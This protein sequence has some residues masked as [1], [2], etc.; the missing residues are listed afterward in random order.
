MT[1]GASSEKEDEVHELATDCADEEGKGVA[2]CKCSAA[3]KLESDCT[4]GTHGISAMDDA[5][6]V[7][8]S[9][10]VS[11]ASICLESMSESVDL[12]TSGKEAFP[13]A[14]FSDLFLLM[15]VNKDKKSW[16]KE[17]KRNAKGTYTFPFSSIVK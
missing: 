14:P 11:S 12:L 4:N 17:C 2:G 1:M 7:S 6:D 15:Q 10:P 5:Q 8:G 16:K 13:F 9:S 3:K